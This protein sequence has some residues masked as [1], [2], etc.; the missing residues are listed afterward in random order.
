MQCDI[1]FQ[2]CHSHTFIPTV[3][4]FPKF[5]TV[6]FPLEF[7]G[8]FLFFLKVRRLSQQGIFIFVFF[9]VFC[10]VSLL[11]RKKPSSTAVRC[12]K[13]G[14]VVQHGAA[15]SNLRG[16][17]MP[18]LVNLKMSMKLWPKPKKVGV[19]KNRGT[20]KWMVYNGTPY[21]NGWFGGTTIFENPQVEIWKFLP[22]KGRVKWVL[23]FLKLYI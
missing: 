20:P 23:F 19:S 1:F 2:D 4:L 15:V 5:A 7:R 16:V 9:F 10:L 21:K 6:F 12:W 22:T 13:K 8:F 17:L 18:G 3:F 11:L 14:R